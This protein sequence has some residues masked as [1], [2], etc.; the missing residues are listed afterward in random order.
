MIAIVNANTAAMRLWRAHEHKKGDLLGLKIDNRYTD[1][2]NLKFRDAFTTDTGYAS[3]GS[4]YSAESLVSGS[5]VNRMEV[6]VPSGECISLGEDDLKGIEFLGRAK[7]IADVTT[8]NC[9]I[10][11]QY[12]LR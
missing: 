7:V 1:D 9:I 10:T 4:A 8:S 6:T 5:A 2:V 12:R 3:G 11:A